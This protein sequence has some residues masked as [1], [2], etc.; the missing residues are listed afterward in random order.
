MNHEGDTVTQVE[1]VEELVEVSAVFDEGVRIGA[2]LVQLVGGAHADQIGGDAPSLVCDM[3]DDVAPQ[4]RR[5]RVAVQED[6]RVAVAALVERHWLAGDDVV[7]LPERCSAEVHPSASSSRA[8][9]S[10]ASN[11]ASAM[12]NVSARRLTRLKKTTTQ[13]ASRIFSSLQP[14]VRSTSM[15]PSVTL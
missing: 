10:S 2:G 1:C 14:A 9:S 13:T 4:V 8:R 12:P 6:D 7:L 11:S 15:S 3:R 5:G